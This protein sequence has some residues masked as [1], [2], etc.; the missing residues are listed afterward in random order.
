MSL[1]QTGCFVV[2]LVVASPTFAQTIPDPTQS[3]GGTKP[4]TIP[5]SPGIVTFP[6]KIVS[7]RPKGFVSANYV[8]PCGSSYVCN[9]NNEVIICRRGGRP[10]ENIAEGECYCWKDDCPYP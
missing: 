5:A 1:M 9:N 6:S 3:G 7:G 2:A 8:G 4:I 10:Y